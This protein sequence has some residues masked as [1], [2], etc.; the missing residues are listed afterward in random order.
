MLDGFFFKFI[1]FGIISALAYHF[2]G[3]IRHLVMDLGHWEEKES[4]NVS[5]NI[6]IVLW[7]LTSVAVGVWL[8]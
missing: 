7:L 3:G 5:A 4:G 2:L 8:W 1:N 6:V